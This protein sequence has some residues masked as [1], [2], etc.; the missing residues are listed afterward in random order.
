[1]KPSL[2]DMA[3]CC[4]A[5]RNGFKKWLLPNKNVHLEKTREAVLRI[6]DKEIDAW[7]SLV[8][9]NK[10][11][12]CRLNTT[13][14]HPSLLLVKSCKIMQTQLHSISHIFKSQP[15]SLSDESMN[16]SLK[17]DFAQ[18]MSQNSPLSIKRCFQYLSCWT[19]TL[20]FNYTPRVY[21]RLVNGA[22]EWVPNFKGRRTLQGAGWWRWCQ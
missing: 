10:Q 12:P 11:C 7:A 5:R 13:L 20:S 17:M 19:A 9:Q 16:V 2:P 4:W 22:V 6:F 21:E 8:H 18:N 3:N 15:A 1:M 14:L